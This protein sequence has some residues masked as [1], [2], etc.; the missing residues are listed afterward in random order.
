MS[1]AGFRRSAEEGGESWVGCSGQ[2]SEVA[3]HVTALLGR[4]GDDAGDHPL[5][6]GA[7]GGAVPA[8]GL[9][10]DDTWPD[11]LLY[12]HRRKGPSIT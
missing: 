4:S 3:D 5:G 9:P 12:L 1:G 6:S 11:G 8:E 2:A 10:V 7:G